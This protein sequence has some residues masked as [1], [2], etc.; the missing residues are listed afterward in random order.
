MLC[1]RIS[2]RE[3]GIEQRNGCPARLKRLPELH[4]LCYT[5]ALGNSS[6]PIRS[7]GR[8]GRK[9]NS[10][11]N[12][13]KGKEQKRSKKTPKEPLSPASSSQT[14]S[15]DD[16]IVPMELL[17]EYAQYHDRV[18][19]Q[20]Q[21]HL[22]VQNQL[23]QMHAQYAQYQAFLTAF[24]LPQL[25]DMDARDEL[26][27]L[28][29]TSPT[30]VGNSPTHL[31]SPT[32]C[33]YTGN[34]TL[35]LH[36]APRE[37]PYAFLSHGATAPCSPHHNSPAMSAQTTPNNNETRCVMPTYEVI[38]ETYCNAVIETQDGV[39]VVAK[40]VVSL[41]S[42]ASV[43]TVDL[44]PE[45]AYR[46]FTRCLSLE[47]AENNYN[48][49]RKR[50]LSVDEPIDPVVIPQI[51]V[52]RHRLVEPVGLE[53]LPENFCINPVQQ[54]CYN[55]GA[56]IPSTTNEYP[57][58]YHFVPPYMAVHEGT[59]QY[60]YYPTFPQEPIINGQIN[61]D[62]Y[63]RDFYSKVYEQGYE[64]LFAD[65]G[66]MWNPDNLGCIPVFPAPAGFISCATDGGENHAQQ[67][68]HMGSIATP[69]MLSASSPDFQDQS[70]DSVELSYS[71]DSD[72]DEHYVH[73]Y[74][75]NGQYHRKY[76]EFRELRRK[77]SDRG[78]VRATRSDSERS[79]SDSFRSSLSREERVMELSRE[80]R[81]MAE[82]L[83]ALEVG[84]LMVINKR[85]SHKEAHME[86]RKA[87][88]CYDY[89]L[90]IPLTAEPDP[91]LGEQQYKCLVPGVYWD[92]RSWIASWYDQGNRCYSSFSAK[93]HGFYKAKYFAIHVRMFKTN[94]LK[95]LDEA[96]VELDRLHLMKCYGNIEC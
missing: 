20:H 91:E 36:E 52:K 1:A 66:C 76:K 4:E 94:N 88:K 83:K 96:A 61:H 67:P 13:R 63:R 39:E 70:S 16:E 45:E 81:E 68:T 92:K 35:C 38:P 43:S 51:D 71:E 23:Q 58:T 65:P 49:L 73:P 48:T 60:P 21:K 24:H 93:M 42:M 22:E 75:R 26:Q 30:I 18:S 89:L 87:T 40:P 33:F 7:F 84:G 17:V 9:V 74:T 46:S 50:T 31:V 47:D 19:A 64:H 57:V 85:R 44:M 69:D 3:S 32:N 8:I 15:S 10:S 78:K 72:E 6:S 28:I 25:I 12:K 62:Y 2:N 5:H 55:N 80:H 90:D 79:L 37:L 86:I 11:K 34:G 27:Q 82:S 53:V 29:Q 95:T 41:C 59:Y 56:I 14:L 54:S 77:S